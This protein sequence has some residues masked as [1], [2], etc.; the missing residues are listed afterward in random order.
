MRKMLAA[1]PCP[2]RALQIPS[3][4]QIW[5]WGVTLAGIRLECPDLSPSS[6]VHK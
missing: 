3:P 4:S 5:L 6:R 1:L 2:F